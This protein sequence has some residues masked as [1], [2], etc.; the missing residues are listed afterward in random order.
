MQKKII[1]IIQHPFMTQA[2]TKVGIKEN[3]FKMIKG[4]Y[5]NPMVRG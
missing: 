5:E 4:I 1:I 2:L 3:F